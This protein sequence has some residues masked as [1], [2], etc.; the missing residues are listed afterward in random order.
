MDDSMSDACKTDACGCHSNSVLTTSDVHSASTTGDDSGA[1]EKADEQLSLGAPKTTGSSNRTF[2]IQGLDCAEEVAALRHAVGP[3]VGGVD[4]LAFDVPNGRMIVLGRSS[5]ALSSQIR[6][7]VRRT[8][9]TAVEWRTQDKHVRDAGDQQRRQQ[10]WTTIVSGLFV[11]T[12]FVIHVWFAGGL[13]EAF[14]LLEGHA[15]QPIP[16]QEI[17][18]Y[19]A[20]IAIGGRFVVAKAWYAAR[21][22]RPDMNL[23]M[24]VA[25]LGAIAIGEW[26]EAATV[27]FLFALSLIA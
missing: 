26:F 4:N 22:L 10:L 18:A 19:L 14:R 24:T 8:G 12:G 13:A 16:W 9:M 5:L 21:S 27:A 17:A 1:L 7:A 11:A 23:L 6:E 25:V 2:A 3:L 15:G 20:A